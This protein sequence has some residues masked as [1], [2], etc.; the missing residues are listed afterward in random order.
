M[1]ISKIASI[2]SV[3]LEN[4][5]YFGKQESYSSLPSVDLCNHLEWQLSCLVC[6]VLLSRIYTMN[7]CNIVVLFL[8]LF[9]GFFFFNI[10]KKVH[11]FGSQLHTRQG[12]GMIKLLE[13]RTTLSCF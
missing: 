4:A 7:D 8:T 6:I 9:H 13:S 5:Q 3:L 1:H 11:P 10:L 2:N 12:L